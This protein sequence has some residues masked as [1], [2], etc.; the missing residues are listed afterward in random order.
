MVS[1]TTHRG[2]ER[3]RITA[4]P[5]WDPHSC[6][7][8]EV[9]KWPPIPPTRV[10]NSYFFFSS[11]KSSTV[12]STE[13]SFFFV[14]CQHLVWHYLL[15]PVQ[16][17]RYTE[18]NQHGRPRGSSC[19]LDKPECCRFLSRGAK[20]VLI[21]NPGRSAQSVSRGFSG[22]VAVKVCQ[23]P[24]RDMEANDTENASLPLDCD[25]QWRMH[26]LDYFF[27]PWRIQECM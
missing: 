2:R 12:V 17:G 20:N 3:D 16:T 13:T 15:N 26:E 4:L 19:G 22:K 6:K 5:P 21:Q 1:V 24:V 10:N 27:F 18:S 23:G 11:P 14:L 25:W 8:N 7:P 9:S